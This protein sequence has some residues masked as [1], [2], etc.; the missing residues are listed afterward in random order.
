[1]HPVESW[2]RNRWGISDRTA[3]PSVWRLFRPVCRVLLSKF[4]LRSCTRVG[5]LPRVWGRPRVVNRGTLIV[6]ERVR[7]SS[8]TVPTE[9]VVHRGARLEIGNNVYLNYGTSICVH[10][11]ITIGDGCVLGTYLIM[12]D[13]DQHELWDRSKL[14]PSRP[15]TL[16]KDVWVGD[17]VIILKGVA[18]GERSVIGAGSVVTRDVPAYSI[19]AGCPARVVRK[20]TGPSLEVLSSATRN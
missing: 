3:I 20:I 15:I 6:G 5:S 10:D 4:Y 16:G 8:T 11:S 18:I 12:A 17:R 1:M 13:N 7:I 19:A 9:L 2:V 14:P